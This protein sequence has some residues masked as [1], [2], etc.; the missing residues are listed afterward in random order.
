[1]S[2]K[3]TIVLTGASGV[4][5]SALVAELDAEQLVCLV[6]R[7]GVGGALEQIRCD[8]AAPFLGLDEA[9][10]HRLCERADCVVHAAA[11]TDWSAPAEMFQTINVGGTQNVIELARAASAPLY[12]VSSAFV[13]ALAPDAPLA[14]DHGNVI[15]NYV[16]SK[17]ECERLVR[18]SGV[19]FVIFRPT[20]LVGDSRTGAIARTQAVQLVSEFIC[21][22]KVPVFPARPHT[23]VDVIPQD[24][25]AR[26]MAAVIDAGE[27]GGEYWLTAGADA[28]TVADTLDLCVAFTARIGR[29]IAAPRIV[30][31]DHIDD[32]EIAALPPMSRSFFQHI[33]QFS[34]GLT[35]CGQFP[36]SLEALSRTYDLPAVSYAD[37]YV[38][39]LEHWAISKELWQPQ[40]G[41]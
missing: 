19:P 40:T 15:V 11:M 26:A 10:Y 7:G 5:G 18:E 9:D 30:H 33:R 2:D 4:V 25:A 12:H 3:K 31:P 20:N 8:V 17:I 1:M 22:G 21:R 28:M 14:L 41:P 36:S 38:R 39:G 13:Q 34:D 6:H 37:A 23:L 35:A 16:K 24:L 32:A 29:G 27:L